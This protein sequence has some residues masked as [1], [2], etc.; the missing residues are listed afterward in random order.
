MLNKL[1]NHSASKEEGFTLIELLVVILI[2]GILAAIAIPMFL[3]QRQAAVDSSVQSD[4]S[5]AAKQVETWIVGEGATR[6]DIPG[7]PLTIN[8]TTNPATATA[9]KDIKVSDGTELVI[10]GDSF[11]YTITGTND[12][13]T[14]DGGK[15]GIV[16]NSAAG[17]LQTD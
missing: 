9:L 11:G 14:D 13:G 12:G 8:E 10:T 3:N 5:N 17:G 2:I 4:V 15:A 6:E 7:D 16:Y 1:R